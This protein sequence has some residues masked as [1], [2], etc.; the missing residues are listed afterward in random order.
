MCMDWAC[1]PAGYVRASR[2][3]GWTSE[4][5]TVAYELPQPCTGKQHTPAHLG[6]WAWL[7]AQREEVAV[8]SAMLL[9]EPGSWR[10]R[11]SPVSPPRFAP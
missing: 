3:P 5:A 11:C 7:L 4:P 2:A 1:Q 9:L 6:R 8:V 10:K